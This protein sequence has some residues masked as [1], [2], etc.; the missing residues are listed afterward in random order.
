[1]L[2]WAGI[3]DEGVRETDMGAGGSYLMITTSGIGLTRQDLVAFTANLRALGDVLARRLGPPRPWLFIISTARHAPRWRT[4]PLCGIPLTSSWPDRL[5]GHGRED[6]CVEAAADT[7]E[8]E[9]RA[10]WG[11]LVYT[12]V[13]DS[14]GD[15]LVQIGAALTL[16]LPVVWV[17][18]PALHEGERGAVPEPL[19]KRYA[20]A[21]HPGVRVV[22]TLR[23]ALDLL[24]EA[25]HG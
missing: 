24:G 15:S 23:E 18:V 25:P 8:D 3:L 19:A 13:D 20:I 1:M 21:A 11:C 16:K 4:F 9:L 10:S 17:D 12:T 7:W 14:L 6:C 5:P 22:A 2:A